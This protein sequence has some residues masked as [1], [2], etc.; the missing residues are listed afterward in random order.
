MKMVDFDQADTEEFD[1]SAAEDEIME[2]DAPNPKQED[3]TINAAET[4]EEAQEVAK[5]EKS[6][7]RASDSLNKSENKPNQEQKAGIKIEIDSVQRMISEIEYSTQAFNKAI[8][9]VTNNNELAKVLEVLSQIKTNQFENFQNIEKNI[10][11]DE[12]EKIIEQKILGS[13]SKIDAK[14]QKNIKVIESKT[15]KAT[16]RYARYAEAFEDPDVLDQFA[17]IEKIERWTKKFKFKTIIFSAAFAAIISAVATTG[18]LNYY[19]QIQLKQEINKIKSKSEIV[20]EFLD[21]KD[22]QLYKGENS[23]QIIFSKNEK[24]KYFEASDGRKVL[25]FEKVN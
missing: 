13:I 20:G 21:K 2:F 10:N 22:M 25:E 11:L 6:V 24:V 3:E 8:D 16:E 9:R 5:K 18:G 7:S 15:K 4:K 1:E 14:I 12:V 17:N 23:N 19:Y